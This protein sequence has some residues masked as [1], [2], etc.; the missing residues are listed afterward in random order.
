[1]PASPDSVAQLVQTMPK[2]LKRPRW[3]AMLGQAPFNIAKIKPASS[4]DRVT[5]RWIR[6][7][8]D[9]RAAQ[10]GY[11]FDEARGVFTVDWVSEFCYLYEGDK[12]GYQMDI[13]DWQYEWF[14]QVHGW[15]YKDEELGRW[16]RRFRQANAWI[17]KKNAKS[18][19]LAAQ[20]LYLL[21]GDGEYGQKCYTLA[22]DKEQGKISHNHAK[23]M[24][25]YSEPLLA[26]CKI[27][28]TTHTIVHLPTMS[29]Y[30]LVAGDN[31]KSTEGFNGST[32]TD[33]VH[34]VDHK[35]IKR[36][37]RAG[38][39]RSEPLRVEM[40]TSG[41]NSDGYGGKRFEYTHR[42]FTGE[43]YDPEHYVMEFAI[44]QDTPQEKLLDQ[45]FI[46]RVGRECNPSM[47][48]I[49][50]F[51]E[52]VAD[53]RT[54][55]ESLTQQLEFA[56]YRL[57]K[58]MA[59]G[60]NW[61]AYED[62]LA[63]S[64]K[65]TIEKLKRYPCFAGLDLSKTRDMSSLVLM[66]AVPHKKLGIKPYIVP[67]FWLPEVTANS[68]KRKIDLTRPEYQG[69]IDFCPGKTIDYSMIA[70]KIDWCYENLDMRKIGYDR[71]HSSTLMKML[72]NDFELPEDDF[73][74]QFP[75]T[76][77]YMGPPTG[78]FERFVLTGGIS[79]DNNAVMNWQMGHV[80]VLSDKNGV[81]K[82]IKPE[83]DDYRKIDGVVAAIMA[84]GV[85]LEDDDVMAAYEEAGSLLLYAKGDERLKQR[86]E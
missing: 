28:E 34:V 23:M 48:R 30:K 10:E 66:F 16:V 43:I 52:Y 26:E 3:E 24:V 15:V 57:N 27:S 70:E 67:F 42:L 55:T 81:K 13:E 58:W 11:R 61:I 36:I 1:M 2:E 65:Y 54:S 86:R 49:L 72:I 21:I 45:A 12:A 32:L 85:M 71:A 60:A 33:E 37:S 20:G 73:M 84:T 47:G 59:A 53:W 62:W 44:P 19:T 35:L 56:M 9:E 40:S 77:Q 63:C 46:E 4:I 82:P 39:S 8:N 74:V 25:R 68:I 31:E 41:D 14:M 78:D 75:Q 76:M 83:Q 51:R 80:R 79:H 38:I 18:P 6:N 69:A 17:P 5:R 64:K 29:E 22:R 50:R 7:A